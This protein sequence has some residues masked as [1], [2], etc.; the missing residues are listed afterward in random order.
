MTDKPGLLTNFYD[1]VIPYNPDYGDPFAAKLRLNLYT[2]F[3]ETLYIDADSL[4]MHNFDSYWETLKGRSFVYE[5]T[6]LSEGEWYFDI[7]KIRRQLS[8]PWIP[9]FNSGMFLF[10]NGEMA[11]AVFDTAF[12]YLMRQKEKNL[13][14]DFFRG[15]M[16][17]DEP[18]LAIALAQL[19]IEPAE[20]HGRFSRTL[21]GAENIRVNVVK[22]FALF[23]KNGRKVFPLIVHFCGRFGRFLLFWESLKLRL[24]FN[25][26][27]FTFVMNGLSLLRKLLKK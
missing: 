12:D 26:P 25:P 18:F 21:I 6:L 7:E 13:G 27:I 16:F 4:I 11:K 10:K 15:T 20:D 24:Y 22:G 9:K 19:G 17:P 8:L 2:P 23:T 3:E 5:G 1:T 14:I